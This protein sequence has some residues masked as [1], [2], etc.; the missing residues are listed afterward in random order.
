MS[1]PNGLLAWADVALPDIAKGAAFYGNLLGW[2]TQEV[3]GSHGTYHFFMKGGRKAAG[4]GLLSEDDVANGIPPVWS[5]YVAVDDVDA[6]AARA[7]ELGGS[8]MV[9]PMDVMDA[10]RMS[11]ITD[12]TGAML[13][14]WQAGVHEGADLFN[15]PGFMSW[16]ELAT[17]DVDA[18]VSFY[19][20]LCGWGA[21]AQEQDGG[22]V[23]TVFT[24]DGNP[25][26]GT[27]DMAAFWPEGI[28]PH[29]GVY[30]AVSDTDAVAARA[31]ELGGTVAGGPIDSPNGRLANLIDDQGAAF[32]VITLPG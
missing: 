20:Q 23:Y 17:T 15:E 21:E 29:W 14:F 19:T 12:P 26:G 13:G 18:A 11:F 4:V 8:V 27:Y 2:E 9:P 22:W 30:F 5:S 32:T 3:E 28:P 6:I 31:A 24:L 10:G 16:N 1:H 25:N 7:P